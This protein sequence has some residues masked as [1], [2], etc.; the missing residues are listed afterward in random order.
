M[1]KRLSESPMARS[2]KGRVYSI[3][4]NSLSSQ[5]NFISITLSNAIPIFFGRRVPDITRKTLY[6]DLQ[7]KELLIIVLVGLIGTKSAMNSSSITIRPSRRPS[8]RLSSK[9]KELSKR[10]GLHGLSDLVDVQQRRQKKSFRRESN[11]GNR[12]STDGKRRSFYRQK[13]RQKVT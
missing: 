5:T 4:G 1:I 11:N 3:F 7:R 10:K 9:L 6:S 13:Y 2:I 8:R 12:I